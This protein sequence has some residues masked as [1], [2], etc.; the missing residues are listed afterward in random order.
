MQFLEEPE[1]RGIE[2]IVLARYMQILSPGFVDHYPNHTLTFNIPFFRRWWG[3]SRIS[4]HIGEA[5][6]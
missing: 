3:P 4:R 2:F 1:R 6:S 5:S